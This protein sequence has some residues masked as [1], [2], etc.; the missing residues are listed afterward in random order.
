MTV[1][2]LIAKLEKVHSECGNVEVR[3]YTETS[4]EFEYVNGIS[5]AGDS[6]AAV[7]MSA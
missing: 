5:I 1:T 2:E 3:A 6:H 4:D 7:I